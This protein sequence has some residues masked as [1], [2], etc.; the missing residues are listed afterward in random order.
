VWAALWT[1]SGPAKDPSGARRGVRS[2]F[3]PGKRRVDDRTTEWTAARQVP[4]TTRSPVPVRNR[5]SS[6]WIRTT[7]LTIMS[8]A[9]PCERRIAWAHAVDKSLQND[10][11][12]LRSVGRVLP[13]VSRSWTLG[14]PCATCVKRTHRARLNTLRLLSALGANACG[15]TCSSQL[16]S[17]GSTALLY[18]AWSSSSSCSAA[19]SRR[20]L[21]FRPTEQSSAPRSQGRSGPRWMNGPRWRTGVLARGLTRA[22]AWGCCH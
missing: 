6:G 4:S 9:P 21:P 20:W 15:S 7:D 17:P 2:R 3:V 18:A 12:K 16:V 1:R 19:S 5:H 22:T 10:R 8:R 11:L 14:G 13:L